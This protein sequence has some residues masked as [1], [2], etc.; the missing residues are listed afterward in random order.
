MI[1]QSKH[2]SLPSLVGTVKKKSKF[3]S[4]AIFTFVLT[5]FAGAAIAQSTVTYAGKHQTSRSPEDVLRIL[6]AYSDTCDEGCT[7]YGPN[8]VKA[9]R[10]TEDAGANHWYMWTHVSTSI[11][12]VHY[13]NRIDYKATADGFVL[14]STQLAEEDPIA[15]KLAKKYS[16]DN[17]PAM[18]KGL[19]VFTVKT[20]NKDGKAV[21]SS[22]VQDMSLTFS[23]MVEM[24][25]GKVL[26]GMKEGAAA[27]FKNLGK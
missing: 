17:N 25:K 6:T 8:V 20:V 9:R 13:F 27:T 3:I 14:K 24:F 10:F 18:D 22:V 2:I 4:L 5:S 23:G 15:I 1:S 26:D 12:D 7:Y 16:L 19:T 21:G 11:K